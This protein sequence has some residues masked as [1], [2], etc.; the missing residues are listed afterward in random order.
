MIEITETSR[1]KGASLYDNAP[2][3]SLERYGVPCLDQGCVAA[4]HQ[5]WPGP[6]IFFR[7]DYA[8]RVSMIE[9][10]SDE[11]ADA[12]LDIW[13]TIIVPFL[14]RLHEAPA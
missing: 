6:K 12:N 4:L 2:R 3:Y 8:G 5:E 7:H 11:M 1:P 10:R 14:L 13:A 9:I